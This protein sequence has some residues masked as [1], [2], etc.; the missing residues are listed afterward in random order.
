MPPT[1]RHLSE[2]DQ[3]AIAAKIVEGLKAETR[4]LHEMTTDEVDRYA[5]EAWLRAFPALY[6][7]A[8]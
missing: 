4:P 2:A 5:R 6:R 1:V 7:G 3:D 8:K